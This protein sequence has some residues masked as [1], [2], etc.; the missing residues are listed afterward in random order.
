VKIISAN[1]INPLPPVDSK[2][3]GTSSQRAEL[4]PVA[5]TS[6]EETQV[7]AISSMTDTDTASDVDLDKVAALRE[8]IG[9]GTMQIN[10]E[11]I[12]DGLVSSVREMLGGST[13]A[14]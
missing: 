6:E 3:A 13:K 14:E 7:L 1:S 9:N 10:S 8:A 5:V 2:A 11:A 12:Y 4:Q